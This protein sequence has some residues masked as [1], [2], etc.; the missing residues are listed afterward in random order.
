MK[1]LYKD[2]RKGVIGLR[3]E[4]ADDLW[5]LKNVI[6]E[7]DVVISKTLRDVKVDGEG[8]RRLPM[9]LAIR[10][11]NMYF[12][13]FSNRL[14]IHGV[15]VDGPEEYGLRGSH[16]TFNIDVGSDLEVIKSEWTLSEVRRLERASKKGLKALLVALDFDELAMAIL[17]DQGI[18]YVVDRSLPGLSKDSGSLD[19]LVNEVAN[20]IRNTLEL[21]K[22]EL[23]V[24]ASPAF[25]KDLIAVRLSELTN[26]KVFKDSV[27]T[28]GRAGIEELVRRDSIRMLLKEVSTVEAEKILEEF[29]ELIVKRPARVAYGLKGIKVAAEA[30]AVSKLLINDDLLSGDDAG[31]YE[32]VLS[33]VEGGGGVVRVVYSDT[34]AGIK[35]KALG[36]VIAILRYDLDT[37]NSVT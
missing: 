8:K 25:L 31:V 22:A 30:N 20:L 14:R 19:Y 29:M 11:K 4:D 3:V 35:L 33:K 16:H 32:D 18:K 2:L 6:K 13:P 24:I 28:G 37:T 23:V 1:V 36:G 10:V 15:V 26:A 21:N 12:Q 7:G 27:S 34:P 5:V 17:Y 9:R